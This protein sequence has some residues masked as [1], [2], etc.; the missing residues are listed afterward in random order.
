MSKGRLIG[1]V[2]PSGVGKDSLMEAL[3]ARRPDLHRVRRVITRPETAGG[4]VFE[5]ITP[6]LF[7]ARAAGG[8]FA[9]HWTAHG[10]SYGVPARVRD[11][12]GTGRDALVNLSR[13]VLGK[14][15]RQF[16]T[17]HVLHVT[18]R[19]E[20]LAA[21]LNARGRETP[22]DIARRL[23]RP[24][25]AFPPGLGWSRSTI[26]GAGGGG[27]GRHGLPLPRKGVAV[28]HVETPLSVLAHQAEAS[29][30]PGFRDDFGEMRA[31]AARALSAAS[32]SSRPVRV[33]WKRNSSIT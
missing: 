10:L 15:A 25:P 5:G 33:R 14:A 30:G 7:A 3:V 9:L 17:F 12:L 13:G 26:P 31:R 4:E 8:D 16:E 28:D 1:V 32:G 29:D 24:A 18:A 20:V 22:Q 27:R 19:P 6:A 2:G 11:V 23:A 21:R